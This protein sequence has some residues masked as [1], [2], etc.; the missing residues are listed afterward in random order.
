MIGTFTGK[1][2]VIFKTSKA[3]DQVL[4]Y[5]RSC[6]TRFKRICFRPEIKFNVLQAPEPRDI[7]WENLVVTKWKKKCLEI[8]SR[9][10]GLLFMAICFVFILGISFLKTSLIDE[11]LQGK[12][13]NGAYRL[14]GV[15]LAISMVITIFNLLGRS[16]IT[17][18]VKQ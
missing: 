10:F 7:I 18:L 8:K 14:R 5:E 9:V 4:A 2:F 1:A 17:R 11:K 6:W 3:R 12:A 15:S 13:L 16:F